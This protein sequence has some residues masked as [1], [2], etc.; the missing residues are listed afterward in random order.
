MQKICFKLVLNRENNLNTDIQYMVEVE[1]KLL[2]DKVYLPTNVFLRPKHWNQHRQEILSSH[3]NHELLNRFLQEFVLNLE[4]KELQ[5]WKNNT[6]LTLKQ[7]IVSEKGINKVKS[8]SFINFCKEYISIS[9][10][11]ESTKKNLMTTVKV[12]NTFNPSTS[13]N[14]IT[15][16]YIMEFERF[17]FARKYKINTII[18]HIKHLRSFYNEALNRRLITNNEDAFR[19]YKML[20][21]ESKYTFLLPE[22]LNKLES[23]PLIGKNRKM[24]HT[25]DVFLFCCYT[26]LRYSDFC[27]LKKENLVIVD[28]KMWL[29]YKSVKTEVETR[30]PLY[31]LFQGKAMAIL[32][33]YNDLEAF[34]KVSSNSNID[35]K[36]LKIKALA[37]I[38]THISFHT[39]R[40]T[41][42][43]LL[44]YKGVNITTVQKLLGHKNIHTTQH[45]ADILPQGIVNDL[46][47]NA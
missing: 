32:N 16:E 34:F 3:P 18:K 7:L 2:S 21:G 38:N 23:L 46:E 30:L 20:K 4:W 36:L 39:A 17:L 6:P 22:E 42:A 31:L 35:K 40:H 41:N 1:A 5:M 33:R 25:L 13:F 19:R 9:R 11:R 26:G 14:N 24:R 45:Y 37:G 47:R 10:K 15:Y 27:S 28:N 43:T 12:L 8:P 44:V 29:M